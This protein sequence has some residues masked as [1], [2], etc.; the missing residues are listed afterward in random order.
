MALTAELYSSV[1]LENI[2]IRIKSPVSDA[3]RM[4]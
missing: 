4:L 3:V 1:T 2:S